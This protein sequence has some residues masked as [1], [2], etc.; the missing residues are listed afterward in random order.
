MKTQKLSALLHTPQGKNIKNCLRSTTPP[1]EK[2]LNLSVLHRTRLRKKTQKSSAI[3]HTTLGKKHNTYQHS[4]IRCLGKTQKF[5]HS[6]MPCWKNHTKIVS[7]QLHQ[8]REKNR[9]LSMLHLTTLRKKPKN[10][11]GSNI[12]CWGKKLSTLHHTMLG[13]KHTNCQRS[14]TPRWGNITQKFSAPPHH[15]REKTQ[16]LSALHTKLGEKH[17]MCQQS[18]TPTPC[19]GETQKLSPLPNTTLGK[20]A[21]IVSTPPHNAG[22]KTQQTFSPPPHQH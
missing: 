8:A 10:Y 12:Q 7:P 21:N 16:K 3:R 22:G 6:I 5:Q 19:W 20:N 14:T 9:K 13:K 18:T 4:T 2:S 1:W 17:K 11:Q 15:A